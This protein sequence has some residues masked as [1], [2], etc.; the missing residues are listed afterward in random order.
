MIL[1]DYQR[2]RLPY[3]VAPPDT[4]IKPSGDVSGKNSE[5][6]PELVD[7]SQHCIK[8]SS[9][10]GATSIETQIQKDTCENSDEPQLGNQVELQE[11]QG[12]LNFKLLNYLPIFFMFSVSFQLT[13]QIK[14][15]SS[16]KI[17]NQTNTSD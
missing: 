12:Q 17:L 10:E 15:L 1:T 5:P 7:E 11:Q 16:S 13:L 4:E 2:G 8:D 9:L 3:F 6:V 14:S